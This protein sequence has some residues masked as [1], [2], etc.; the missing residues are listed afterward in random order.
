MTFFEALEWVNWKNLSKELRVQVMNQVLMYFV[1]PLKYVS[2]VEAVVFE[3]GG[4]KCDTF[5]CKIDGEPFILIPGNEEAILGWNFGTQGLPVSAWDQ[6]CQTTSDYYLKFTKSYGLKTTEEWDAFVNESTSP[7][8][9]VAIPPMLVQ[10]HP[11]PVG[12]QR[13]GKF[14]SVTGEFTGI[15]ESFLPIESSVRKHFTGSATLEDCFKKMHPMELF[16]ENS[17]YARGHMDSDTYEIYTHQNE[18]FDSLKGQVETDLFELLD[19]DAW[20]YVLG[21]GT[22][23]LF[24]WRHYLEQRP[25][26]MQAN[27]FGLCFSTSNDYWEITDSPFLKLEKMETV[28]LPLFDVLPLATYYRSRKLRVNEEILSPTDYAYRK[29]IVIRSS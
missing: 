10:K 27:M 16:E 7:L 29:A 15:V 11:V 20:E 1:S 23:K 2:D 14:N 17:F 12:G 8:R 4:V 28:G 26:T 24:R 19:E 21:A 18:T 9:K 13:I 3:L 22:R 25:K 6:K 5:E